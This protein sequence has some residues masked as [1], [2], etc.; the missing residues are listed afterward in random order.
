MT[1]DE[2][3]S[4]M[5]WLP[6]APDALRSVHELFLLAASIS[7]GPLRAQ[8]PFHDLG[9]RYTLEAKAVLDVLHSRWE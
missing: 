7:K 6:N 5:I 3:K 2:S 4:K 1:T 8:V 9:C